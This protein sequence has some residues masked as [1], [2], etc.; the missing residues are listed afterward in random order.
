MDEK[1]DLSVH[2]RTLKSAFLAA[3]GRAFQRLRSSRLKRA[4]DRLQVARDA[5]V[6][7]AG[8]GVVGCGNGLGE[9]VCHG[10]AVAGCLEH[11]DVVA[12]VSKGNGIGHVNAK[13]TAQ[14]AQTRTLVSAHVGDLDIAGQRGSATQGGVGVNGGPDLGLCF[15]R[16]KEDVYAADGSAGGEQLV[17]RA[18]KGHTDGLELGA[19][20]LVN[21][22]LVQVVPAVGQV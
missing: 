9:G 22:H 11:G 17:E 16:H 3:F 20:S 13:V 7:A 1:T 21:A 2:R 5:G 15:F 6:I 19:G 14:P 18:V 10:N 12:C 8:G 4:K